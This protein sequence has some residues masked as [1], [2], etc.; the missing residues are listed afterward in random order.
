MDILDVQD[1]GRR[2][3]Q[4]GGDP[5]GA[6]LMASSS[7]RSRRTQRRRV[8]DRLQA[9]RALRRQELPGDP[10]PPRAAVPS[11]LT[12]MNLLCGFLA[13]TQ[14][15]AGDFIQACWLI[16][17]A[18][19]FDMID[20]MMARLTN[21]TSSFGL[22]LDSLSDIVSFGVAPGFLVYVFSLSDYGNTGLIISSLPAVCGA[23]REP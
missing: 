4:A 13:I 7:P 21:G 11:F 23:G 6:L 19:F 15:H 18:G 2:G 16:V 17:I 22:E 20:G 14:V 10:F 5:G 1:D 12:L 3:G 8:R 9:Y